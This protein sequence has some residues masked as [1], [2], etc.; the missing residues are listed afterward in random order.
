MKILFIVNQK[1]QTIGR[2]SYHIRNYEFMNECPYYDRSVPSIE[3]RFSDRQT[4]ANIVI[5]PIIIVDTV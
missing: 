2:K 3:F 5:T 4:W 1:R